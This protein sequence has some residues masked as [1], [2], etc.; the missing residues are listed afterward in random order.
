[1]NQ[2]TLFPELEIN[3]SRTMNIVRKHFEKYDSEITIEE[4]KSDTPR[5]QK[6]LRLASKSWEGAGVPR[7]YYSI[8]GQAESYCCY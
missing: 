3:E 7:F 1:M 6:L 4:Q 2:S 5:I 8:Q